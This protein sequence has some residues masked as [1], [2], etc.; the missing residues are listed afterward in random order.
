MAATV[1]R[2][3]AN[4]DEPPAPTRL[5]TLRR[6]TRRWWD[7]PRTRQWLLVLAPVVVVVYMAWDR[8]WVADDGF[9][10]LRVVDQIVHGNGPV[11]NA[12]ERVEASTS[13]LWM[14]LLALLS[15]IPGL[16]LPWKAVFA[17][18]GFTIVAMVAAQRGAQVLARVAGDRRTVWP[19]GTAAVAALPP[20]WD[21]ATSGLETGLAFAWIGVSCWWLNLR[22]T[23]REPPSRRAELAGAVWISLAYTI[24]PDMALYTL[25][26]GAVLLAARWSAGRRARIGLIVALGAI[27]A[28]NQIF[29]MGYYAMVVPNTA[30]A[31]E[32]SVPQWD[33]G[34]RYL[35]DL[36]VPYALWLPIGL[37]LYVVA[38]QVAGDRARGARLVVAAR[39]AP[40][41][42]A[43]LHILY[44]TRVGGDFM[45][46][47]LL[48][49]A[50]FALLAPVGVTLDRAH[51][52]PRTRARRLEV[53]AIVMVTWLV[54]STLLLRPPLRGNTERSHGMFTSG[55]TVEDER[56][57]Y[58]WSTGMDNPV[59]SDVHAQWVGMRRGQEPEDGRAV[60][61]AM[62]HGYERIDV[63]LRNDHPATAAGW[64]PPPSYAWDSDVYI[65]DIGV[66]GHPVGSRLDE[67]VGERIGHQKRLTLV[68]QLA[69]LTF[70]PQL[71]TSEGERIVGA[72]EMDAARRAL[73]CGQLADYLEDV[74]EPLTPGRFLGNLVDSFANTSLRVPPDPFDAEDEFCGE[75]GG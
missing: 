65:I 19:I 71:R 34:W 41:A 15:Y 32:A 61:I 51:A 18:I 20:F 33:L 52:A 55:R 54:L 1:E 47:R 35:T 70:A 42:A 36:V 11:Y 29:R 43:V 12:S 72:P 6:R 59:R 39:L 46:G 57:V 68:W 8:R 60:G 73:S 16:G 58:Q 14:W 5:A 24:R 63:P 26:F 48:L 44:M 74:R 50:V 69:E 64:F 75:D 67:L 13:P 38:V 40:I 56:R 2:V 3:V 9:I 28:A 66:L 7:D 4:G 27:P 37:A 21:Y 10:H 17:G 30:V 31:K 23:R 45:H 53:A 22:V 62:Q 49:P 25:V